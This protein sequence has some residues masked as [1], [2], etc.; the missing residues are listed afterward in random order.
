MLVCL[1][2]DFRHF[3]VYR[4][5][6]TL[7]QKGRGYR[8]GRA[9]AGAQGFVQQLFPG[10]RATEEPC[11]QGGWWET[12]HRTQMS[13]QPVLSSLLGESRVECQQHGCFQCLLNGIWKVGGEF[14]EK[15]RLR[16]RNANSDKK[17]RTFQTKG[18][19]FCKGRNPKPYYH[20]NVLSPTLNYKF[21]RIPSKIVAGFSTELDII[22]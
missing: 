12:E 2:C 20:A 4:G 6:K 7:F 11:P 8:G 18:N 16:P 9:G 15:A 3:P 14:T 1:T 22:I 21:S 10:P 5:G 19:G 17:G 13:E